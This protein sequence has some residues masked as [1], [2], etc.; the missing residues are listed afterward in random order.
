[1][2]CVRLWTRASPRSFVWGDGFIGTQTHLPQKFSFSSDFGH[3]IFENSGRCKTFIC[4]KKK[5]A[6]IS[7]FLGGT[8]LADFST[9]GDASPR[10]QIFC[11]FIT[12]ITFSVQ[13]CVVLFCPLS[14]WQSKSQPA[15]INGVIWSV[16]KYIV[17]LGKFVS[18]RLNVVK[19]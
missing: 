4:V 17:G 6:E 5:H 16:F 9:A 3:F 18:V 7:S 10:L 2:V 19:K 15:N 8:S 12:A 13:L 1:M 11:Y 14:F